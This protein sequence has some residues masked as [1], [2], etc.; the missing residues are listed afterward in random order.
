MSFA[1][2]RCLA[3]LN[4]Y[5]NE[6]RHAFQKTLDW[7]NQWA[8][9]RSYGLGSRIPWDP[10]YLVESLSDSTIYMAYYTIAHLLHSTIDGSKLGPAN[11]PANE[12]TDEVWDYI[13]LGKELPKTSIAKET[14]QQLRDSFEYWYPLDIRV[15]GKDLINNHLTFFLYNHAAIFDE[16][17]WPRG[18]RT[19]GHLMLNGEKM[20]KS[21]GNSMTLREGV[22][23]FGAD[24]TRIA[25]ADAGDG[26][27]DA[28][29][30]ENNADSAVLR[31]HTER[32]WCELQV[33]NA[34]NLRSGPEYT[35]LDKV[36]ENEI[37]SLIEQ[38][39]A[40]YDATNYKAALKSA[41]FDFQ[42]AKSWYKEATVED[43]HQDLIL[44]FIETQALLIAPF[45]PHWSEYIWR[46]VLKKVYL[47]CGVKL[48]YRMGLCKMLH[49]PHLRVQRIKL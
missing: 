20:S 15:S 2:P 6:V 36:F 18:I 13:F 22:D 38:T 3:Q 10:Q 1:N 4:T 28:N 25:L 39:T 21:T 34:G 26:M 29:F 40:H 48:M 49:S 42:H 30:E 32:E 19:N 5:S 43:V 9:A 33:A 41:L 35:F 27:D 17:N 31:L 12:M 47:T 46:E 37:N 7:L 16:A 8:C 14:L 45:A 23:K 44:R 24:A 11:V